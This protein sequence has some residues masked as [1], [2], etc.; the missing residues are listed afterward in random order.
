MINILIIQTISHISA[1]KAC[2]ELANIN[3]AKLIHKFI[4]KIQII[5]VMEIGNI[6][7]IYGKFENINL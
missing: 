3:K 2:I 6:I 4:K 1:L 5:Q 7:T